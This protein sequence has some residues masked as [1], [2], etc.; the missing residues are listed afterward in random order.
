M[1]KP[2]TS[3]LYMSE[4]PSLWL[5]TV[6]ASVDRNSAAVCQKQ[7]QNPNAVAAAPLP[8]VARPKLH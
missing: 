4:S 5:Q 2:K 8:P 3:P 1:R 7:W 6:T